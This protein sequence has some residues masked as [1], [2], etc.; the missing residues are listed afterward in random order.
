MANLDVPQAIALPSP[1]TITPALLKTHSITADEY[2]R[3]EKALGRTP[4][5]TELGIFS[6]MWSEHCSYKSSRVHL[7]RLPTK[8]TRL[9]GPGSVVQG[10]GENAGIIDVGDG[11]A[12][13]FKIESHNH[14]SYIEP[15]QGAATGVGG[16][17]RDIFTMNA[18]PL[19]VMDSLRFGP[20][21][22]EERSQLGEG[23][24]AVSTENGQRTTH[25]DTTDYARNRQTMS[26]VV[27]GVGGYGNCFGVPNLGGETRFEPCYSGNPLLNAFALGLVKIDEIFYAKATGVGNPV[28]YVGAKT[29]RD[30]IHGATMASEE[31]TEGSEQKRPNVQM[32]DPFLEKLLLEACLEAMATGAVLGIQDMGAAGLTCS[33]CEMGARGEL[34]LTIELD[35]VPQRETGMSSY[36]IMLSESQERMLLVADKGR[37]GEVL[38]VFEK[39][40]LDASIIGIVTADDTM[41]VTH[42]G[43]LVC[44]I[45][46][47]ALTDDAP[48]YHRPVGE[49]KAPVPLDPP[50]WVLEELK[51][52][53]DYA[54]DLKKLLASANICSKHWI[55]EQYD[56]M[57]QTNTVQGP[58]G[59]AGVM[60]IKGT[61]PVAQN[62]GVLETLAGVVAASTPE[63]QAALQSDGTKSG[64]P[65]P[66]SEMWDSTTAKPERGL[67][68]ALAG[69]GRWTYLDPKLGAMH[70][71]AEAARKVA[72]TGAT[73][74]AATN[75]LNF[76]NPEKP[77]IM[78]QLSAAIDG[79]AEACTALG[80]PVT[81]GNVSL[82]NE[83]KGEGIYPTPVI[84]IVGILDDVTKA[85]PNSFQKAGDAILLLQGPSAMQEWKKGKAEHE[86]GATDFAKT[87]VGILWG[88]PHALDLRDEKA[89]HDV[90][91]SV[92]KAGLATSAGDIS[93]G[94]LAVALAKASFANGV[95]PSVFPSRL[96]TVVDTVFDLFGEFGSSAIV[97]CD[98]KDIELIEKIAEERGSIFVQHIGDCITDKYVIELEDGAIDLEIRE[99]HSAY[100]GA[101]E[102]QL[103]AEVLA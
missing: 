90:L 78:A 52:P 40:G 17:L 60:R 67:A 82:Y 55:F 70:A 103:A 53:R 88:E 43:E 75:C 57:V 15:Y 7:K 4:S 93:D 42:H 98:P 63:G 74:V 80:T 30:G 20:L 85:V 14:P 56:S 83:T 54:A 23:N 25:N 69:N 9:T 29:G 13:A 11:W 87:V 3:I 44:E 102:S 49:W 36:E 37:E 8:G 81:G 27:H 26:G 96:L 39:W 50:A 19:A 94:G 24:D 91:Q 1:A 48:V 16:I 33:T 41:R 86:L 97:T 38:A 47:K 12:C 66:A 61:G 2:T 64:T 58:G 100:A 45:P 95:G 84:G 34:G 65:H 62:A 99:L 22:A 46:N 51:K 59:E 5:L 71:V 35:L 6:V 101:L 32:G 92:A 72:C 18:R 68:M 31:F 76:G 10:P 89:L 28:I 21:Q 79:I 77:E 73:P